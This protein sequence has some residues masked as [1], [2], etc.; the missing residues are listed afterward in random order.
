MENFTNNKEEYFSQ[1]K[2][3]LL[4]FKTE[5]GWLNRFEYLELPYFLTYGYSICFFT[6]NE[7]DAG[8]LVYRKWNSAYDN[9]RF[10]L[11]IYNIDRL[12]ITEDSID[13]EKDDLKFFKSLD[14]KKMVLLKREF[15]VLD[16][17]HC[18]L[19]IFETGLVHTWNTDDEMSEALVQLVN[20][21]RNIVH[22]K[23]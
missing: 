11:G 18:E 6:E 5:V 9:S 19:K 23:T 8:K 13:I 14:F 2:N 10:Q 21:I 15:I 1:I 16:G 12:A 22:Q 3:E 4:D 17:L 20:R 7:G